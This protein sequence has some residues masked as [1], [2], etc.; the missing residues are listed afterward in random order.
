LYELILTLLVS[1]I[2]FWA[3]EIAKWILRR[4]NSKK[5]SK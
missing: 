4:K 2:V 5:V 1:S 3:V